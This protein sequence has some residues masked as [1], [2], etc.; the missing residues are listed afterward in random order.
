MSNGFDPVKAPVNR[1]LDRLQKLD[2]LIT[3]LATRYD[4]ETRINE[5]SLIRIDLDQA[6]QTY[7]EALAEYESLS[8]RFQGSSSTELANADTQLQSMDQKLDALLVQQRILAV[9]ITQLTD[10]QRED[11]EAVL[12]AVQQD[13]ISDQDL[14]QTLS[15]MQVALSSLQQSGKLLGSP[16]AEPVAEAKA[17]FDDTKIDVKH[18]LKTTIPLIPFIL[19]YENEISLGSGANLQAAWANIKNKI[20]HKDQP[21]NP[22]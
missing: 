16:L 17:I 8:T 12:S 20:R 5:K 6:K 9:V 11:T 2:E 19:S 3:R 21:A 14:Q 15:A 13:H 1:L 10:Q 22:S 7:D 4:V 18:K